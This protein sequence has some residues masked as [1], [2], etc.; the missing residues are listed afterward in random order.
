MKKLIAL[1][2]AFTLVGCGASD[3]EAASLI[4]G[5]STSVQGLMEALSEEY[6]DADVAVQG[7]GSSVG[8][9]GVREGTLDIGMV[10]RELK[11]SETGLT[12]TVIALDGIAVIV[13]PNNPVADLT[14]EQ[15]HDIFT[16]KITNWNEVG[17]VDKEIA[18][19]SREEGSGTRGAFEE[20]VKYESAE[21]IGTS[22]IQKS[23]GGVVQS[24]SGNE[25]AIGYI[26]MGSMDA[27]V[28]GIMIGGVEPTEENA[29]AK[30]YP[31]SRPFLVVVKEGS[32]NADAQAFIDWILSEEGQAIVADKKYI[33]VE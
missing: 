29:K 5:G 17:G 20:I 11:D 3:G 28:K 13:H 7:G 2:M 1:L 4:V 32:E 14:M 33:T 6:S 10:S 8:V 15:V 24:V 22:E 12:P 16:G 27:V 9:Q 26:S 18:V 23:T 19:V 25:N 21:L 30:T 31:I